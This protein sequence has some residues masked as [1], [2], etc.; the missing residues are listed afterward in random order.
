MT[1]K[2]TTTF[3]KD[4]LIIVMCNSLHKHRDVKHT[5]MMMSN[6]RHCILPFAERWPHHWWLCYCVQECYFH[7]CDRMLSKAG[8]EKLQSPHADLGSPQTASLKEMACN[9]RRAV[10]L[11]V[12]QHSWKGMTKNPSACHI[13]GILSSLNLHILPNISFLQQD[14]KSAILVLCTLYHSNIQWLM[15]GGVFIV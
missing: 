13:S 8:T 4:C 10:I 2:E 6:I 3:R 12:W 9:G 15:S 5:K 11:L 14:K 7:E 1:L